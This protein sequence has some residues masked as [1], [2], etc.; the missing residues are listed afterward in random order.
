MKKANQTINRK[1]SRIQLL[2]IFL[3]LINTGLFSQSNFIT[4]WNFTAAG[5]SISFNA[6]TAGGAVNYTWTCAPSGNT[7]TGTFTQAAG[8]AV[9]LT[10]LSIPAGNTVTLSMAPA[11]LRRF[12]INNGVDRLKLIDVMQWGTVPWTSMNSAFYYCSNLNVSA[13]D[14]PNL[15]SVNTMF[16]MFR[17][18]PNLT[19]PSNINSWNTGACTNMSFLFASSPN[20]NQNIGG[21][22]TSA[23]TNMAFMFQSASAFNQNIGAWNTA[24]C[25]TMLHMFN[26]A[27]SFNQPIGT[28]NTSS[29]TNM[30]SMFDNAVLFN[31]NIGA[32]NTSSCLSFFRMFSNAGNF[33]QNIGS[34]NTSA[35]INMEGMFKDASAF[36]QPIAI[37]NTGNCTNMSQMFWFASSFNQNIGAWNT[38]N[39]VNMAQ[40]FENATV[41]NQNIGSWNTSSCTDMGNMFAAANA[42][43]QNIGAW[44]TSNCQNMFGMFQATDAFNQPIGSWNTSACISMSLMFSNATAFNQ[45]ISNWNTSSCQYM[46]GMF[47]Y[48]PIFNQNIGTWNIA[49][50]V[51]MS[52]M[53]NNATMFNR[54]LGA[55]KL[56]PSV[57]ISDMLNN[58]G[59]DCSNYTATLMG[60]ATNNP[61]VTGRTLGATGRNYG[62]NAVASRNTLTTTR[63]WTIT[64]DVALGSACSTCATLVATKTQT[65]VSCFGGNNGTAS[66]T[67]SG[68]TSFVYEWSPTDNPNQTHT[69]MSAGTY[70][71]TIT[72]ECGTLIT[73]PVTITQPPAINLSLASQTN[74]S[75]F[76]GT[77]GAAT[78]NA[79]TGGTGTKTYAW[80][81]GGGTGTTITGKSAGIYT[82]TVTDANGC[83]KLLNVTITQPASLLSGN[84]IPTNV[85]C[86]GGTNGSINLTASGGTVPY[87]FN[88]GGGITTEDRSGLAT[89]SY[90]V[91]ITDANG[92]TSIV[93]T[94]INQPP[95]ALSGTRTLTNVS[96]FGGSN[97]T[98]NLTAS[99]GTSP[100]TYNWGGGITTEDR[101]S[102]AA[103]AYSVTIADANGC[104]T[105]VNTTISEP[106]SILSGTT[107]SSNVNCFGGSNGSINLTASGGTSPYT[108]NWGGGITT[109]D[110]T[111]LLAG[112]Y[113]VTI[114]DA[115]GCTAIV[116]ATIT[117]PT[118]IL[119]GT[120]TSSNVNCFGGSNGTI[121]LTAS[122]G[123]TPY[124]YNWGG[125]ITTEDRTGLSAGSYSVTI[126]DANGCT[127]NVNTT[128]TQP[129][130]ALSGNTVT[131]NVT[132]S[133]GSNGT[134][135]LTASGGTAPYSFNWG[136]GITT[137][138]RVALAEGVYSVTITDANGCSTLVNVTI[139]QPN[140]IVNSLNQTAC[141][142]YLWNGITYTTSGQYI[143]N[144][145]SLNGCDSTVTMNLTINFPTSSNIS[146]TAC[147]SYQLNGQTYT[148]SGI[149]TQ[150]LTNSLGCD[151]TITLNLTIHNS[152]SS[153]ITATACDSY[154]L[155]SQTYTSSGI[156]TQ[157]LTNSMGCDST[158]NL[159]LTIH[160]STSSNIS[161]TACDSYQLNSQ[162]YTSSGMF[163]QVIANSMGCDSTITLNLTITNSTSS[164]TVESICESY[165]WLANGIT[166]TNSGTY[167]HTLQNSMACDS[168]LTLELSILAS[169]SGLILTDQGDSLLFISE[170]GMYQWLNCSTNAIIIGETDANFIPTTN[171][172]YSVIVTNLNNCS[173]TSACETIS[174]IGIKENILTNLSIYPNP[175]SGFVQ[176]FS[177]NF[178]GSLKIHDA[179]GKLIY[180]SDFDNSL[181]L[182]L[183]GVERGVYIISLENKSNRIV[184]KLEIE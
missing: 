114:T 120:T 88:W 138:D 79:A 112:S 145:T 9:T 125:G 132:C 27:I 62:T 134:I 148:S 90:S 21:W 53:F 164:I 6:Q 133:G 139:T 136:S 52:A 56:N 169:P 142:S 85:S 135:D 19:G 155:N 35:C 18:C 44:N 49:N 68:G 130:S 144:L 176:V 51:L 82:C 59:I 154:D 66:V 183:T 158:I 91:T 61:T 17:N 47:Q 78:V 13:T 15:T 166:Y 67:P 3:F 11:N 81:P 95:S 72:N 123:T 38:A 122:G 104:T 172:S 107:T 93:N 111:G 121:N 10:G 157:V 99:G 146:A 24:S 128:I 92:C 29:C 64:G 4:K 23:C 40:M 150:V 87:T 181:T 159:N 101:S 8:G 94:T 129:V 30:S 31:Q 83:T 22:N 177:E 184:R 73:V 48:A 117:E 57:S 65:N 170:P 153:N 168:L 28:W 43:N 147:D 151:S 110:R 39:C 96:C 84:T 55:W 182:D 34:W 131:T 137:E 98:I 119:S 160:N 37:W 70:V 171:G 141:E 115:N 75:C 127:A 179:L 33:N 7:G 80:S 74:V 167:L 42:F 109:E 175:S 118:S 76:G 165:T 124:S 20:F 5:T 97:G 26:F 162:T 1:F 106:A 54:N 149:F 16:Q 32:W 103:G 25:T 100:Y 12:Y 113:S 140:A 86:F 116:N 178:I 163:T 69:G 41:F 58:C 63:S 143:Q 71:C 105:I 36:N 156:F 174:T 152:T 161:T 126:T 2:L 89:G 50:V 45:N 108:Y 77:N 180:D 102:L 46:N 14:I 60:W 173:D